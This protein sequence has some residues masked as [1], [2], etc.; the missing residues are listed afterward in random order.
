[1]TWTLPPGQIARR[2]HEVVLDAPSQG[3]RDDFFELGGDSI[4]LIIKIERELEFEMDVDIL[5]STEN[6]DELIRAIEG[7]LKSQCVKL[8]SGRK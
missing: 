4:E 7:S 3:S 6:F 5:F 1:M 8:E 2:H